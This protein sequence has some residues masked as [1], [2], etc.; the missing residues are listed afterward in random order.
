MSTTTKNKQPIPSEGT[1]QKLTA[2]RV[3]DIILGPNHPQFKKYGEYDSIGTIFYTLLKSSNPKTDTIARPLF[4][5]I[6][7]Y[8]LLNE[9]VLI[10]STYD[11]NI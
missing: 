4:S 10:V 6:K 3:T 1:G 2:V 9:I 7:N 11:K 5:F 8:P